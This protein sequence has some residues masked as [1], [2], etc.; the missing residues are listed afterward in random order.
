VAS[1]DSVHHGCLPVH[2]L[3]DASDLDETVRF[4]VASVLH[5][6]EHAHELLEIVPLACQQRELSEERNDDSVEIRKPPYDVAVLRLPMIVVSSVACD[7]PTAEVVAN[8]LERVDARRRLDHDELR[9]DLPTQRHGAVALDRHAEATFTID[10]TENPP[11]STQSF[12]LIIRTRH[13]FTTVAARSDGTM[14][15]AGCS[16]VPAY[17]RLHRSGSL[18]SGATIPLKASLD[19]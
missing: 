11:G 13:I 8:D 2:R 7:R 6:L 1:E 18:L 3:R 12:L 17:G 15:N 9:L 19:L 4:E 16:D 14:S 5:V 10:E